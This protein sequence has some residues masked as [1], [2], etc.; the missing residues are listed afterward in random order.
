MSENATSDM[1]ALFIMDAAIGVVFV[2][3]F[4]KWKQRYFCPQT[5]R[6]RTEQTSRIRSVPS[7]WPKS[8]STSLASADRLSE[9]VVVQAVVIPEGE[10]RDVQR[11]ILGA[12]LVERADHA[13]LQ[14]RPEGRLCLKP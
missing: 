4:I 12:D 5:A 9:D 14:D 6:R 10:L 7:R 1:L 11:R 13:A 3:V 2:Y 8:A